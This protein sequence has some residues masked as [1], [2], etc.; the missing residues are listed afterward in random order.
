[1][2]KP[3][4]QPVTEEEHTA[5]SGRRMLAAADL[6]HSS[7]AYLIDTGFPRGGVVAC[8][9]EADAV[10]VELEEVH[11]LQ[12]APTRHSPSQGGLC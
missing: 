7:S 5:L 2:H 12:L 6:W 3:I 1:M 11:A 8:S 4:A 9:R 10:I